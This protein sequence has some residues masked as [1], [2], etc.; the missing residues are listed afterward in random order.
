MLFDS[1]PTSAKGHMKVH[2]TAR[3]IFKLLIGE[4]GLA[5]DRS[6]IGSQQRGVIRIIITRSIDHEKSIVSFSLSTSPIRRF[7]L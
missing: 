7:R 4:E 6:P 3:P 2:E 5:Y 1:Q